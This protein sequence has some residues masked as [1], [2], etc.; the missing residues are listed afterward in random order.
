M[1]S[2]VVPAPG[3]ELKASL[4]KGDKEGRVRIMKRCRKNSRCKCPE[5]RESNWRDRGREMKQGIKGM[6]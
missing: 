1:K 4:G 2:G 3:C 6:S 5:T